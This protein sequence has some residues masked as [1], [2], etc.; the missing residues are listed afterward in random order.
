MPQEQVGK[1]PGRVPRWLKR[2]LRRV[3]GRLKTPSESRRAWSLGSVWFSI[4]FVSRSKRYYGATC[5]ILI[6][7]G[8]S[9]L[10]ERSGMMCKKTRAEAAWLGF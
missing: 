10:C 5:H 9:P 3:E 6:V 2:H 7:E 4:S 1:G 8:E